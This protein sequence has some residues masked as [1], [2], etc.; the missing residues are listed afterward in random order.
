MGATGTRR[1]VIARRSRRGWRICAR[2]MVWARVRIGART[3]RGN[4]HSCSWDSTREENHAPHKIHREA[5]ESEAQE[6]LCGADGDCRRD[7][8]AGRIYAG[9]RCEIEAC[10]H[11]YDDC[12]IPMLVR[13]SCRARRCVGC[14]VYGW[15]CAKRCKE[16]AMFLGLRTAKY[17]VQDMAKA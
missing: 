17:E 2:N 8:R 6:I 9:A 7:R 16:H 14:D 5:G 12:G 1:T 10:F 13:V 4:R 3:T 11:D 15:I